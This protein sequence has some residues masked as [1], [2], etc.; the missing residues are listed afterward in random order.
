[1]CPLRLLV[2]HKLGSLL[3]SLGHRIKFHKITSVTDKERGDIDIKDY[4]ILQNPQ[5]QDNRLPPPLTLIMDYTMT[6]IRSQVWCS[7]FHPMG[8]LTNTRRSDGSPD[9]DG[10]LKEEVRIKIRHYRNVYLNHPDPIDFVPVVV[11]TTGHLYDEFIRP[12]FL[13]PH[14]EVSTLTNDLPEESD[15][16]RFLRASCFAILNGDVGLIMTKTSTMWISIAGLLSSR[17]FTPLPRFIL[18]CRPTPVLTPSLVLFPP[19]SA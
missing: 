14:R 11:D 1:M 16:F 3:G 9:P 4:V 12:L 10:S 8:Q 7:H 6:H 19:S 15:Q 5:S 13:Y 17:S 2:V 18:S